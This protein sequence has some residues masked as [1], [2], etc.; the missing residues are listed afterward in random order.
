MHVRALD[1]VIYT[2]P[3]LDLKKVGDK[4]K[5]FKL[6]TEYTELVFKAGGSILADSAEGRL[7]TNAIYGQLDEELFT[8]FSDIRAT[9]DPYG[10]LNPE[11]KQ[12]NE[13]HTLVQQLR[14]NYDLADFARFSPAD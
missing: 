3:E 9:F 10:T 1:G 5:L 11:V 6:M 2:R 14:S 7:K 4:Q 8:L 13:V 12:K